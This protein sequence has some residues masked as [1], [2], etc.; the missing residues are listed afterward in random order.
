MAR[1]RNNITKLPKSIR[2]HVCEMLEDGAEYD[3]VRTDPEVA[4]ACRERGLELHNATFLAYRTGVEYAEF[5][6]LNASYQGK[7]QTRQIAAAMVTGDGV[8][9]DQVDLA[10]YLLTEK[11]LEM[12]ED[13]SAEFATKDLAALARSI[14]D[15]GNQIWQRKEADL[16]AAHAE[17]EAAYQ[18]QIAELSALVAAQA[19]QLRGLAGDIDGSAVADAMNK[20]LG[21]QA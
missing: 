14:K 10:A 12:L 1:P 20:K 15:A 3:E 13:D 2:L 16:K 9:R 7:K 4:A 5:S 21:I 6:R 8:I 11:T 18:A 19:E 17:K